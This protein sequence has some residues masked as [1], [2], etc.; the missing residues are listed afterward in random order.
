L[1][2]TNGRQFTCAKCGRSFTSSW[3]PEEALAEA[4]ALFPDDPLKD[5][6]SVC[7][8]CYQELLVW[9]AELTPAERAAMD[10][11]SRETQR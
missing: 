4:S 7:D 3:T 5:K 2:A 1:N 6:R 9:L 8:A 10:K 11:K